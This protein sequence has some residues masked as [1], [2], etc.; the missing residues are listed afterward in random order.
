[1]WWS[2]LQDGNLVG[3]MHPYYGKSMSTDFSGLP[4]GF[5]TF[6]RAMGN[7]WGN[8]CISHMPKYSTG[9][10]LNGKEVP[11]LWE[12]YEF[13][14]PRSSPYDGFC[15]ILPYCWKLMGKPM[16]FP[17]DEVYHWM[18]IKWEKKYPYYGKSLITNFPGFPHTMGFVAFSLTVGNW[19][20]NSC[21]S[22]ITKYTMGWEL[23]GKKVPI[24]WE[25]SDYQFP[26]FS[27]C[28]GFCCTFSGTMGNRCE[29]PC[30]SHMMKY[31]IGWEFEWKILP[32]YMEKVWLPISQVR[33]CDGYCCI[34]PCYGKLMGKPKRH[35]PYHEIR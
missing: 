18:G 22:H 32:I 20:E 2:I 13:Q 14:F 17:Y 12:K 4:Q 29:N 10:K 3:E 16:D 19:W 27:S 21:I 35:F 26:R 6:S 5:A 23:D 8:P 1:M 25:K 15:C 34:F 31:T 9:W 7:W 30:I 33:P 28:D 11:I 24:L